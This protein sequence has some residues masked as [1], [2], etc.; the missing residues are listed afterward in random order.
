MSD[1]S[2]QTSRGPADARA[3]GS[4]GT[5]SAHVVAQSSSKPGNAEPDGEVSLELGRAGV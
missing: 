3:F 5:I 2:D 1:V 4:M